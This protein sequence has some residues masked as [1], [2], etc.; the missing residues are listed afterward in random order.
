MTVL[1]TFFCLCLS[2]RCLFA[3]V[4]KRSEE[5]TE[6]NFASVDNYDWSWWA[7][8]FGLESNGNVPLNDFTNFLIRE[9]SSRSSEQDSPM[10]CT[11]ESPLQEATSSTVSDA[12]K[13]KTRKKSK[14]VTKPEATDFCQRKK[15]RSRSR[16]LDDLKI[17]AQKMLL[18]R[19]RENTGM[20]SA[21]IPWNIVEITGWPN[22]LSCYQPHNW[23]KPEFDAF[24]AAYDNIRFSLL[25]RDIKVAK[26]P[27]KRKENL[28][29]YKEAKKALIAMNLIR[30]DAQTIRW[31][32]LSE[33][34]PDL[35]LTSREYKRWS[36]SDREAVRKY[37]IEPYIKSKSSQ[38]Y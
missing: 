33:F 4:P 20:Q 13:P 9:A 32:E 18:S 27:S 26:L 11:S 8:Q 23:L 21:F 31:R 38:K 12:G 6:A 25:R 15:I 22:E 1:A 3:N 19:F 36:V 30:A 14:E 34:A 5:I 29:V 2:F 37:I 10:E 28:K 16:C 17:Q 35:R 24:F 7:E